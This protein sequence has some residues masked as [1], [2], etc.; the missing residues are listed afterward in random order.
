MYD[1]MHRFEDP[2]PSIHPLD[3]TAFAPPPSTKRPP[4]P[5]PLLLALPPTPI[6]KPPHEKS[7]ENRKKNV[8]IICQ[9][10]FELKLESYRPVWLGSLILINATYACRRYKSKQ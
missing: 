5:L 9:I 8:I 2:F 1:Y 3:V 7:I 10:K 4:H 6:R